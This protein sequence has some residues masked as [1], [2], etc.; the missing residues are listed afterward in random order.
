MKSLTRPMLYRISIEHEMIEDGKYPNQSDFIEKP[1][2]SRPTISRDLDIKKYAEAN[3]DIWQAVIAGI[4]RNMAIE[5][6]YERLFYNEKVEAAQNPT[7]SDHLRW[8]KD[9]CF[10]YVR[11]HLFCHIQSPDM[12]RICALWVAKPFE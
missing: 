12:R 6:D 3:Q 7:L 1:E 4:K 8:R 9:V 5:F 11:I 10:G 2:T